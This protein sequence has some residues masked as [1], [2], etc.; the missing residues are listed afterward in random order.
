MQGLPADVSLKIE[1]PR[2]GIDLGDFSSLDRSPPRKPPLPLQI[3]KW[4]HLRKP[5][6]RLIQRATR[7]I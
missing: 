7:N 2:I 6:R 4:V 5:L 3:G 1:I